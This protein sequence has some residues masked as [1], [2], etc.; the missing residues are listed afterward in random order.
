MSALN[1]K[2]C[3]KFGCFRLGNF[4]LFWE[5]IGTFSIGY[6]PKFGPRNSL[7]KNPCVTPPPPKKKK[8]KEKKSGSK[9][10]ISKILQDTYILVML[11]ALWRN[12][13]LYSL[14]FELSLFF[15]SLNFH[16][17]SFKF[18]EKKSCLYTLRSF[19]TKHKA[20]KCVF[21]V[22]RPTIIFCPDTKLFL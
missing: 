14:N 11:V 20:E 7:E 9:T 2:N 19:A 15:E 21:T 3:W 22:T 8:E 13:Q 6:R 17:F 4:I 12:F 16:P 10:Q 1:R 5:N 18:K